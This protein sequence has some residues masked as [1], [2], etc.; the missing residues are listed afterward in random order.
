M[1]CKCY[2]H[3]CYALLFREQGQEKN[4]CSCFSTDVI[5]GPLLVESTDA[6]PM[7]FECHFYMYENVHLIF[8]ICKV[9]IMHII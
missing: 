3:S 6:E 8:L 9:N 4:V 2:V 5:F 7:D 1:Q